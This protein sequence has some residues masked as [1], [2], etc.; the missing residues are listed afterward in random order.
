[1]DGV[2]WASAGVN[3]SLR[4]GDNLRVVED[5]TWSPV[6]GASFSHVVIYGEYRVRDWRWLWLRRKTVVRY[7]G[8]EGFC[9]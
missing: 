8:S 4:S 2:D 1:M 9:L 7:L 5:V 3:V 6:T